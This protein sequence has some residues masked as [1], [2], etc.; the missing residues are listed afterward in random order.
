M[1]TISLAIA[2][3]S[4]IG[5]T[6]AAPHEHDMAQHQTM[7]QAAAIHE[8]IGVLKA[9]NMKERKVQLAH[10]AIPS[11]GW[12]GMTMWFTLQAPL[13]DGIQVGDSVRFELGRTE[14]KKWVISKIERK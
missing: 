1:K 10:E 5:L 12:P 8:G 14:A 11:L 13:P 2:L 6:Q 4:M 3:A 7:S 9:I